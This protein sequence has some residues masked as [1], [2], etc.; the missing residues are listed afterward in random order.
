MLTNLSAVVHVI[1]SHNSHENYLMPQPMCFCLNVSAQKV[2]GKRQGTPCM[3]TKAPDGIYLM[4]GSL[5]FF[6]QILLELGSSL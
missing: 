2:S 5:F 4:G 3:G 6:P 1:S